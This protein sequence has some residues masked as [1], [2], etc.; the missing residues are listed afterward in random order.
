MSIIT[1]PKLKEIT[2][3]VSRY[4]LKEAVSFLVRM[5]VAHFH[6]HLFL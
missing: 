4:F 5:A 1:T 6:P 3:G 2:G